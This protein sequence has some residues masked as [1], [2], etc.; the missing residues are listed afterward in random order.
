V[1]VVKVNPANCILFQQNQVKLQAAKKPQVAEGAVSK[2]LRD[3]LL[4]IERE[5]ERFRTENAAVAKIKVER[6]QV[7][8]FFIF[9]LRLGVPQAILLYGYP[10]LWILRY[11]AQRYHAVP[12]PGFEPRPS[13]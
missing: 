7:G 8:R 3:K 11:P 10:E 9:L 5:I 13:G 6:E 1:K 2:A 4:E 12:A